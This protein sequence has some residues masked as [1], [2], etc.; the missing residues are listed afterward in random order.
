MVNLIWAQTKSGVIG[1]N[2]NLPWKIK[3]EMNH[4]RETTMYNDILMGSKT[5]DSI[6]KPLLNRQN[7]VLTR[8]T[9]KYENYQF[10]NLHFINNLNT[11]LKPYFNNVNKNIYVIGGKA[12]FDLAIKFADKLII[13][14]INKDYDGDIYISPINLEKFKLIKTNKYEDFLVNYYERI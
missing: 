6:K 5:F 3:A 8:N 11:F 1:K 10:D 12:I 2:N 4:F 9:N 13:S 14:I 7:Y